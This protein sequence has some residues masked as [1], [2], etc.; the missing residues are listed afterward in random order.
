MRVCTT[1]RWLSGG[2]LLWA[3]MLCAAPFDADFTFQ[4]PNGVAINVHGVGDE[5]FAQFKTAEDYTVVY[6][7]S[8]K[9]YVYAQQAADGDDLESTGQM[10]GVVDPAT[11]GLSK[12]LTY[13]PA[14]RARFL[15]RK[16]AILADRATRFK[17]LIEK[18]QVPV[19]Q[20]QTSLSA[21][22]SRISAMSSTTIQPRAL[23]ANTQVQY[24]RGLVILIDFL[25]VKGNIPVEQINDTMNADGLNARSVKR[26]FLDNSNG[27]LDYENVVIPY[28]FTMPKNKDYY[29]DG[30]KDMGECMGLLFA[31]LMPEMEKHPDYATV[32]APMLADSYNTFCFAYA[33]T[34]NGP[35]SKGLWPNSTMLVNLG[36][37][38]LGIGTYCHEAGHSL[39]GF[40]D[41]YA[42]PSKDPD[43]KPSVGGA[44]QYCLMG[45][46]GGQF[47]AWL[48][49]RAGWAD[50]VD[51]ERPAPGTS[52]NLWLS[53]EGVGYNRFYRYVNP[54]T[55][56]VATN[57][58]GETNG[59]E[60]VT[61][62]TEYYL[63]ENRQAAGWDG[64]IPSSGIAIWHV[65]HLGS[66]D[67]PRFAFNTNHQNYACVLM[68]GDGAWDF[69][70]NKNAGDSMDLY[71]STNPSG[72]RE[73]N[74]LSSPSARWW[75]GNS[76]D[77]FL[78]NFS[79]P[80]SY[81]TFSFRR[82]VPALTSPRVLPSGR[83]GTP[84]TYQMGIYGTAIPFTWEILAG[85]PSGL[86]LTVTNGVISGVP[87]IAGPSAFHVKSTGFNT[88][89]AEDNFALTIEPRFVAPYLQDFENNGN[90]PDGWFAEYPTNLA[91]VAWQFADGNAYSEEEPAHAFSGNYNA[92]L[93]MLNTSTQ[94]VTRLVTPHIQIPSTFRDAELSFWYYLNNSML[95][96]GEV[97]RVYFKT[98][99]A[100]PWLPLAI[101]SNSV[102]QWTHVQLN[103]ADLRG[104]DVYFAFEGRILGGR[105]ICLDNVW[106]Y[107]PTPALAITT[108]TTLPGATTEQPY[109]FT[110]AATN[111]VQPYTWTLSGT[112]P[113][114]FSFVDG[115]LS[116]SSAEPQV[117]AFDVTVTDQNSESATQSCLFVIR[118]PRADIFREDFESTEPG[119]YIP[120]GWTQVF[121]STYSTWKT[122]PSGTQNNFYNTPTETPDGFQ[123]GY[124]SSFDAQSTLKAMLISPVIDLRQYSDD[125]QLIF[126]HYMA[127]LDGQ[128]DR[129]NVYYRTNAVSSWIALTNYAANV[130]S[131]TE[132]S[133]YLPNR[134]AT[135][136]IAFES[137]CV[138][139]AG[140]AIDLVRVVEESSV[141]VITTQGRLPSANKGEAYSTLIRAAGEPTPYVWTLLGS[142]P[143][144]FSL[145]PLTGEISGTPTSAGTS[146]FAVSVQGWDGAQWRSSTNAFSLQVL[147]LTRALSENFNAGIPATWSS[148]VVFQPTGMDAAWFGYAGL[149]SYVGG[150]PSTDYSGSGSNACL[151]IDPRIIQ[152]Y[153]ACNVR[154]LSPPLNLGNASNLVLTFKYAMPQYAYVTDLLRVYYRTNLTNQ[155]TQ[156]ALYTNAVSVWTD[157]S[158]SL[159]NPNATYYL[160]FDSFALG[161][162]GIAIDDVSI[163]GDWG[164]ERSPFEEWVYQN[165]TLKGLIYGGDADDV[166]GDGIPN[167]IKYGMGLD[168]IA[169]NT[170]LYIL[171]GVTNLSGDPTLA[172]GQYLYLAYR[173]ALQ[174]TDL[175]FHVTSKTNLADTLEPWTPLDV[176]EQ[177]P[178]V[179]GEPGVWAWVYNFHA[180]P[181][182]NAPARFMRL[183]V[184]IP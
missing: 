6:D 62:Y 169:T 99:Y 45:R 51:L 147:E 143:A 151:A 76:S 122:R 13:G 57:T 48:K 83:V 40:P 29:D 85:L 139:G 156:I 4:Q 163:N 96:T 87:D 25:D 8:L 75:N 20:T 132:R 114:G 71:S 123:F 66:R 36:A 157:A 19:K 164:A 162:G 17:S 23:A 37:A 34:P 125:T 67:D 91:R 117:V 28:Y 138:Y 181:V 150:I 61:G 110:F 136:Q 160:A 77:L 135:Y 2:M 78:E 63:L 64:G 69:N 121:D 102:D 154:L 171:G 89:S 184:A 183:E 142:L 112:L 146:Q 24:A 159:P 153:G 149:P 180:V 49:M 182:T 42:Y 141:P 86:S 1:F 113:T 137:A 104:Q 26:F 172:D 144:G 14:A 65:D 155:W 81:M 167:L 3:A 32:I 80:A 10:V 109:S 53:S 166:S 31:D 92:Y 95:R 70:L 54:A 173:R 175:D 58:V 168:P 52:T 59:I 18:W 130:S 124:V 103:V 152:V 179:V 129:L 43:I 55:M 11:L 170:G 68:P 82:V 107:D 98:D 39:C 97:L 50:V 30:T 126:Y 127:A 101:Y 118:K 161:G 178:W 7:A 60:V 106:V 145:N 21:M 33:G 16:Q 115:V 79:A 84:Y 105:G 90:L 133:V 100:A 72:K 94:A 73:F 44:G 74:D 134:T 116:G 119:N 88:L 120:S 165:F 47:C 56:G 111:G 9:A 15:D 108:G 128:Q 140:V 38:G 93:G 177:S 35:W 12:D 131:W 5:Y 46:G 176:V 158:I 174:V 41:L 22:S 27:L 148:E